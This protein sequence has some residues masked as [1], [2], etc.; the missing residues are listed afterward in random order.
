MR[1]SMLSV[2]LLFASPAYANTVPAK[3]VVCSSCH[4]VDTKKVG[5]A[6]KDVAAKRTEKQI[7]Q[8]IK[9][10]SKGKWVTNAV[11]PSF[12]YLSDDDIKLLAKWVTAQK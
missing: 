6:F 11:M 8:S 1:L 3:A 10:G 4:N 12:R 9:N 5:P 7:M 2:V